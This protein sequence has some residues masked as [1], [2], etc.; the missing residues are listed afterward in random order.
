MR[1]K[2]LRSVTASILAIVVALSLL[3]VPTNA[4]AEMDVAKWTADINQMRETIEKIYFSGYG[5]ISIDKADFQKSCDNIVSKLTVLDEKQIV[6]EMYKTVALLGDGHASVIY[7]NFKNYPIYLYWL[8]DGPYLT[9]TTQEYSSVLNMRLTKV[10]GMP[11]DKVLS[12]VEPYISHDNPYW[13]RHV[14]WYYITLPELLREAGVT[15]SIESCDYTFVDDSGVVKTVTVKP[16]TIDKNTPWVQD[17]AYERIIRDDP[18]L[19]YQ[20]RYNYFFKY[21]PNS[22]VMYVNYKKCIEN[23]DYPFSSFMIDLKGEWKKRQPSKLVLDIRFNSGGSTP[24]LEPFLEWVKSMEDINRPDK[25]FVITGRRTFSAAV[26][27]AAQ[28]YMETNATFV[29]EP[30]GQ[31]PNHWGQVRSSVLTNSNIGLYLSSKY[32]KMMAD[33]DPD[34]IAPDISIPWNHVD[35]FKGID[36]ILDAILNDKLPP[37]PRITSRSQNNIESW[38]D[39]IRQLQAE[40]MLKVADFSKYS[41]KKDFIAQMD[42]LVAKVPK[43]SDLDVLFD[44]AKIM[45]TFRNQRLRINNRLFLDRVYW[46]AIQYHGDGVYFNMTTQSNKDILGKKLIA[47]SGCTMDKLAEKFSQYFYFTDF[48]EFFENYHVLIFNP[49]VL[50]KL[51]VIQDKSVLT[52]TV[53]DSEGKRQDV[54]L[55]VFTM[56]ESTKFIVAPDYT[57]IPKPIY[58]KRTYTGDIWDYYIKDNKTLYVNMLDSVLINTDEEFGKFKGAFEKNEIKNIVFD[59]RYCCV[60]DSGFKDLF[61]PFYENLAKFLNDNEGKYKFYAI[62]DRQI[63]ENGV[64]DIVYLRKHCKITVVGETPAIR[65][66]A[67]FSYAD[68][69]SQNQGVILRIPTKNYACEGYKEEDDLIPDKEIAQLGKYYFSG[70]DPVMDW[71][72]QQ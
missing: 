40:T 11:F 64:Y 9:M 26:Q 66:S 33:S 18:P 49:D 71:I 32:M 55:T 20:G 6:L 70:I 12:L 67:I 23:R 42:D 38:I 28:L 65:P 2:G 34:T 3:V 50:F 63:S 7:N 1:E 44:L 41:T 30:V 19:C 48:Y 52:V 56:E 13:V 29:G 14:L 54:R 27:N 58:K 17:A 31:K 57:K 24:I 46:F 62:S 59:Y 15:D 4:K 53:E 60:Y 68:S 8:D 21:L 43:T 51:G 37:N 16:L 35:Y 5:K 45:K 61:M 22:G 47:I 10:A 36:T 69:V 72:L 39:D 25:F